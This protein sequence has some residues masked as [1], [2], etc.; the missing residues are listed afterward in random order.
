METNT[1]LIKNA[2]VRNIN[3]AKRKIQITKLS[4]ILENNLISKGL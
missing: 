2:K 4:K 3:L 1:Q